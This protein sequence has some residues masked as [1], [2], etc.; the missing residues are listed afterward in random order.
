MRVFELINLLEKVP[1][2]SEVTVRTVERGEACLTVDLTDVEWSREDG[3]ML[4]GDLDEVNKR[5]QPP[6]AS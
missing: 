5:G 3:V 1:E 2:Q 4:I 6:K